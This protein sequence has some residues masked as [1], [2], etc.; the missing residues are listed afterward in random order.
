MAIIDVGH[1]A[2]LFLIAIPLLQ[3][4]DGGYPDMKSIMK[5]AFLSPT[6]D[7]MLIGLPLGILGVDTAIAASPLYSTYKTIIEFLTAPTG[8]LILI[9]LGYDIALRKDLMKPVAITSFA[10][11]GTMAVFCALS[12]LVIFRF[13][14]FSKETLTALMLAFSLPASYANPMFARFEGHKD[15]VSTTISFSTVLTLLI[16][17]GLTVY[18]TM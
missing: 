3:A 9:T 6:F 2:F 4:T 1:T 14:P 18:T 10:R 17:I 15:Y 13:M 8:M 12:S 11:L 7:A 16:F 5:N